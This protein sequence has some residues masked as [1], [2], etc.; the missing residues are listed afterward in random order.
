MRATAVRLSGC[1]RRAGSWRQPL[2]RPTSE[3]AH[4][5]PASRCARSPGVE[6]AGTRADP[7][8]ADKR[9]RHTQASMPVNRPARIAS[10]TASNP[11]A[12]GR[13]GQ[14]AGRH[15]R[16]SSACATV[17]A[18]AIRR[19]AGLRTSA[20]A[21]GSAARH[22]ASQPTP[23]HR[24]C[25]HRPAGAIAVTGAHVR[26]VPVRAPPPPQR[27]ARY[28]GLVQRQLPRGLRHRT[29]ER[30]QRRGIGATEHR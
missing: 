22:P 19:P 23:R 20:G 21:A 9:H 7:A 16:H 14:V 12:V 8:R 15:G 5:G 4:T 17:V 27:V 6:P 29:G 13:P 3:R 30:G 10:S 2:G 24:G 18:R 11:G 1:C 25:R 26:P 28:V